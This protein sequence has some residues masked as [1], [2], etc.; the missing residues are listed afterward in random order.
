MWLY[1]W[2]MIR[3][4]P[5]Y[6]HFGSVLVRSKAPVC[7][8][9]PMWFLFFPFLVSTLISVF[10]FVCV[11]NYGA[12][13]CAWVNENTCSLSFHH[14]AWPIKPQLQIQAPALTIT[15]VML[16]LHCSCPSLSFLVCLLLNL[17][18][19]IWVAESTA[20]ANHA[21]SYQ[22]SAFIYPSVKLIVTICP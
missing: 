10:V 11:P 12:L 6:L 4:S 22:I 8:P 17:P 1:A 19:W 15:L 13:L 2:K 16:T 21:I 5:I 20:A 9:I 18:T 14:T 3:S 7:F